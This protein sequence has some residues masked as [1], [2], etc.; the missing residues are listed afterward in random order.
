MEPASSRARAA[1]LTSILALGAVLRFVPIWFGLPYVTARPDEET[2]LG[3]AAAIL[4]G[5]PNPHFFH[6]PSLTFYVFAGLFEVASAA[7]RVAGMTADLTDA[8]RLLIARGCVA[9]AGTATIL[10]LFRV[11]RRIGGDAVGLMAALFLAVSMLHVRESHFAMTDALMTFFAMTSL[12]LMLRGFAGGGARSFMAAGLAGGLA[13]STKYTAVALLASLAVT[14]VLLLLRS[15]EDRLR[16][17]AASGAFVAFFA[18]GVIAATPYAA[19]DSRKFVEDFQ[20][21]VTH[22]SEGHAVNLGRGWVYHLVRS[23]PY[24]VSWPIF[25]AAIAGVVPFVRRHRDY[26]LIVGAFAVA[27]YVS[28][29]NGY[30][31]FFRYVLPIVPIVCLSAAVAIGQAASVLRTALTLASI[32]ALWGAVNCVWFDALLARK[33]SRVLAREWLDAH[34]TGS[35]TLYEAETGYSMLDLRGLPVHSWQYDPGSDSFV[36]AGGRTPDWLVLHQSPLSGYAA[37]PPPLRRLAAERY[38]VAQ[39]IAATKGAA[40]SAIYDPQDAFFMPVSGFSTV[41]RAGPTIL[42][43]KRRHRCTE[44]APVDPAD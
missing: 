14:H 15:R 20:F 23:L 4:G 21:N 31:V 35:E 13:A 37:D 33:D 32:V 24:G 27:T 44:T 8:Q 34:T 43:Y 11:G 39:T 5:D 1:A 10:V 26:A 9:L 17:W 16:T 28:L 38:D 22:L 30:T 19:L 36:N 41:I 6:W 3:H 2:S 12:A 40:R 29:G 7:K 18:F 42:I 25:I